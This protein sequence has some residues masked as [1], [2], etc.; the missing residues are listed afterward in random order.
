[1]MLSARIIPEIAAEVRAGDFYR[2]SHGIIFATA[3]ELNRR[4]E[5]VDAVTLAAQLDRVVDIGREKVNLLDH[6]GG[7][8]RIHELASLTP[9]TSNAPHHARIV[10]EMAQRRAIIE[11]ATDIAKLGWGGADDLLDQ[12]ERRLSEVAATATAGDFEDFTG[13]SE[14]FQEKIRAAY[15]SGKPIFGVKTGIPKLDELT[16]G[17]HKGQF[18]VVAARPS[19]GKSLLT[20]NMCQNISGRGEPTAFFSLEMTKEELFVRALVRETSIDARRLRTGRL[21]AEQWPIVT[22]AAEKI[23]ALPFYVDDN[24]SITM[25]ELRARARRMKA[26]HGLELLVVDYLQLMPTESSRDSKASQIGELS[27]G[28]KLLAKELEIPVVGISQLSRNLEY[29]DDKRPI[30]ADLRESGAIEQ[31]ADLV[32][33]IYREEMYAP[34][35][36]TK[37]GDTELIVAKN[38]MGESGTIKLLF[39][40]RRQLFTEPARL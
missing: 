40:N 36:A 39:L 4:G 11:A 19:M 2:P 5:P 38:R 18:I 21:S 3:L 34:V 8:V 13:T 23:A 29:R 7:K 10:R 28:L 22:K 26:K 30:L 35:E 12:A 20:Q 37:A 9:A 25:A 32:L 14:A 6:V 16:T 17:F 27:R 15:E 1:M 31:D 24:A 33:F